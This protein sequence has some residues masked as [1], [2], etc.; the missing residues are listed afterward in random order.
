MYQLLSGKIN[1]GLR[2]WVNCGF[3]TSTDAQIRILPPAFAQHYAKGLTIHPLYADRPMHQ[4]PTPWVDNILCNIRTA[5][6]NVIT[7]SL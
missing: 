6:M 5:L 4:K 7:S 3:R 2:V 1:L